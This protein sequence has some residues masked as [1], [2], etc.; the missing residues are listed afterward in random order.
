MTPRFLTQ[1]EVVV[2]HTDQI[3]RY[4]GSDGIRDLG[5]LQSALAMPMAGFGG[6]YL[7]PTLPEMAAA[8]LFHLVKNH[9]FVDGNKRVAAA[10]ANV[11]LIL[12]GLTLAGDQDAYADLVLAAAG[13]ECTKD[14]IAQFF[15]DH[16]S[17]S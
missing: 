5:L 12:N 11:F 16:T 2:I 4:G 17:S 7:H 9:P 6:Q 3:L 14:D 13:S 10:A 8:Y 15:R 1:A